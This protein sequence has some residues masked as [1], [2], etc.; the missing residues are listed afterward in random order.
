MIK[1]TG[2]FYGSATGHTQDIA[3][4]IGDIL[5]IRKDVYDIAD[6]KPEQ[7]LSFD[8]YILGVSTWDVGKLQYDWERF[9]QC[10]TP[11]SLE[12][13]TC[14]LFGLGDQGSY[15]DTFAD[16]LGILADYLKKAGAVLIGT[17]A[18]SGYEFASSQAVTGSSFLG[19]VLDEDCQPE[20]T[21]DRI[22]TWLGM[23]EKNLKA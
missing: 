1:R 23:I 19:L 11:G 10:L 17:W 16:G 3:L 20:L 9:I 5:G 6:V 4:Q 21:G 15:P 8:Q 14:A 13:K 2:I 22:K 18:T 7:F 12:G